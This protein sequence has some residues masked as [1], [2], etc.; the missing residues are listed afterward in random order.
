L[1]FLVLHAQ[2]VKK[3]SG[4][5]ALLKELWKD[6]KCRPERGITKEEVYGIV[7]KLGG[8]EILSSFSNMVETT[9][10]ID[11]ETALRTIG[12]EMRWMD[13]PGPWLGVE[14][15]F[16]GDRAIAKAVIMDSPAHRGGLNAGDE[17]I[18]LNGLRFLRE[19]A[20]KFPTLVVADQP[21]EFIISRLGKLQRIEV[22]PTKGPKVLKELAVVD[23]SLA[24]AS[25]KL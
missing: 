5:T 17:L 15:D 21:Y 12:I 7:K 11:F 13:M 18:F 22:T 16:V 6:F 4:I 25:F 8:D 19:D 9:Q 1:V 2:L 14:W 20:E 23:R 10:D 3:G 24:E